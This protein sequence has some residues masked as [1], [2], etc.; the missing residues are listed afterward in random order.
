MPTIQLPS[1]TTFPAGEHE[2]LLDAALAAGITLDHSCRSGRCSSCKAKVVA[3]ATEALHPETGLHAGES[4]QGWILTCVRRAVEDVTLDADVLEGVTLPAVRNFPC[5]ISALER[6]ADDVVAITLRLPPGQVMHYF[7]GQ[8]VDIERRD[9][10]RRSYS[11]ANAPRADHL[12]ELQVRQVPDGAMSAYW[13]DTA[14]VNDLLQVK[15]PLGS[16]FLREA[17]GKQVV[18]LATGTGIAPIKAMLQQIAVFGASDAPRSI[19]LLWGGRLPADLYW[20][21]RTIDLSSTGLVMNYVPVLSRADEQ[22][23]G[24]RGYVQDVL[25]QRC[26]DFRDTAVYACGSEAMIESARTQLAAAGL[27]PKHF[28]ADA[29]LCS[30]PSPAA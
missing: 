2:T 30:A 8:Y 3:G 28:Y 6:L 26:Q 16:F 5:K 13:F 25:L 21:P 9:G 11:L 18:L 29:F 7:P 12:L 15:G 17:A 20:D 23:E 14:K 10:V 4:E 24:A 19:T 22:W 1:G 27:A